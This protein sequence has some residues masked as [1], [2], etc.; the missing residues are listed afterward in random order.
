MT[1]KKAR[2][3][4]TARSRFPSGMTSKKS[5]NNRNCEKQIPFGNDNKKGKNTLLKANKLVSD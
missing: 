5:K 3:T 1:T 2:T 4:A